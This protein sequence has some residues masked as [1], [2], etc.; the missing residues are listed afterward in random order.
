M[1]RTAASPTPITTGSRI[2]GAIDQLVDLSGLEAAGEMDLPGVVHAPSTLQ[3]REAPPVAR[4]DLAGPESRGADRQHIVGMLRVGHGIGHVVAVG[5]WQRCGRPIDRPVAADESLD[6]TAAVS[7]DR[8]AKAK[9]IRLGRHVELPADPDDGEVQAHQ[10]AIAEVGVA[11]GVA[12]PGR[13]VEV[14]QHGLAATIAHLEQRRRAPSGRAPGTQHHDVGRGLHPAPRVA[15]CAIQIHDA[16]VGRMR[17]VELQLGGP[18]QLLVLTAQDV[19]AGGDD[20]PANL[21]ARGRRAGDEHR[22]DAGA[23][24]PA[25]RAARGPAAHRPA[26]Q[27]R[28]IR[29]GR[30]TTAS[31]RTVAPNPGGD[32]GGT[33]AAAAVS[34]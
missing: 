16:G 19:L 11:H 34:P 3:P 12:T 4:H 15:G 24:Q 30:S 20:Q 32:N 1:S 14:G 9:E 27:M 13:A 31:G 6:R 17:R 29:S 22:D 25:S 5:E 8:S 28:C 18:A 33:R 21:G 10:Q 23:R 7:G 26:R 2:P